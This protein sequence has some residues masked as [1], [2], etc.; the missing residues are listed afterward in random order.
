MKKPGLKELDIPLNPG[1]FIN[2]KNRYKITNT[3]NR[4]AITNR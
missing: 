4:T 2:S 3:V 1:F